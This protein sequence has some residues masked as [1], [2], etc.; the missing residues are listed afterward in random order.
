M[1]Q[2]LFHLIN[3][4]W[5]SPALD[6]FMAGLSDS[7]IWRPFLIAIGIAAL[8]FGGFKA[9]AFVICLGISLAIAGL[10]T[11][12]LKS[13]VARPRPKQVQS[14][15]MVQ[16]QKARPKF[17]TLF[18]KSVI[19][20]SDSSDRTR[21]GPSFPSGHTVNNTIAATYCTLFYRRRGWL[22]WF[23]ALAVGYSRIYL[24]AH[25]P[26]DVVA[27]LF[28]GI[29][30]AL[31]LLSLFEVTW[32]IAARKWMPDVFARHPSLVGDLNGRARSPGAP[33]RAT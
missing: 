32:R 10:I 6:L 25:W 2:T 33:Q 22:Y 19:R 30:E 5:T 20:F 4:Q 8:V 17:L 11:S 1:D 12:A 13:G 9:R 27:T 26:T 18:K 15:R 7:Q 28:L 29:A 21:S 16:L 23:V 24:G 14:V 31:F 3:Q